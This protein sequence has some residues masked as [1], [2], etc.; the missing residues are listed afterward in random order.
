MLG[1]DDESEDEELNRALHDFM[2]RYNREWLI[3]RHGWISPAEQRERLV[4]EKAAA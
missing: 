4:T 1:K 2:D 3:E